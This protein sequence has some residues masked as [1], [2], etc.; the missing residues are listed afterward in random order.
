MNNKTKLIAAGAVIFLLLVLVIYLNFFNNPPP[1]AIS[2]EA[3]AVIKQQMEHAAANPA[4][5][6]DMN[7]VPEGAR[8]PGG[9]STGN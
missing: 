5:E 7:K 4:P 8:K 2:T 6:P 9:K 1:P 3:D